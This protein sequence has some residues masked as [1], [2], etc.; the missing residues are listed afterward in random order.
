MPVVFLEAN[1][2]E[3]MRKYVIKQYIACQILDI[4]FKCKAQKLSSIYFEQ[5]VPDVKS[6]L[7]LLI[8]NE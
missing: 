6:Q 4:Y 2:N 3:I 1:S 7:S 8:P 5:V